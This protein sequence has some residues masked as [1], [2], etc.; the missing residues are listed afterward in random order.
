MKSFETW[1][2]NGIRYLGIPFNNSVYIS[3]ENGNGFGTWYTIKSF[4]EKQKKE[5]IT[6]IG[7][8]LLSARL[9]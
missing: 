4:C 5:N 1:K 8:V 3:D 7:N 6:P 9:K 2:F